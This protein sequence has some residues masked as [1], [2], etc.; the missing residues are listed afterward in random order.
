MVY[1]IA[2]LITRY[3]G[4]FQKCTLY[5]E[6]L[7]NR[8]IYLYSRTHAISEELDILVKRDYESAIIIKARRPLM[9]QH[10]YPMNSYDFQAHFRKTGVQK[11][12]QALSK[13]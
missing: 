12:K 8:N 4:I 2:K 9:A 7:L 13:D 3:N 11:T 10:R 1:L 5:K 6:T